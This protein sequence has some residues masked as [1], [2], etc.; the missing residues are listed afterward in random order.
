MPRMGDS[1]RGQVASPVM[2][3][4]VISGGIVH[5][6]LGS[7][8]RRADVAI[9]GHRVVAIGDDVGP[10]RRTIDARGRFVAPGF[11]DAHSHSDALPMM[12]E[13]AAVQ[14]AAGRDDRDR[15]ELR[16]LR[17][18]ARRHVRG[19]RRGS[20]GRPVPRGG[21]RRGDLR[22]LPGSG[23]RGRT[24]EQHRR[25]RR[26]RDAPSDGERHASRALGRERSPRCV[27]SPRRRSAR[28]RSGSR[29][30]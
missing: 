12:S 2:H 15:R 24:D 30:G 23:G 22:R 18:A 28:G 21:G 3:D 29:P 4:L 8:G 14:A 6:G 25:A 7:P 20:V 9:D 16:V 26:S 1:A 5:D 17:R 13:A 10:A 19:L 27:R 11:I